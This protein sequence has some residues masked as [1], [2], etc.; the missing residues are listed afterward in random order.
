[1]PVLD[2]TR[3]RLNDRLRQLEVKFATTESSW[4]DDQRQRF[5]QRHL[6]EIRRSSHQFDQSLREVDG[7]L[8]E[9]ERLLS[10]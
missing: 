1:M 6:N 9:V 4:R 2:G 8:D 3:E 10:D 5:E 7:L